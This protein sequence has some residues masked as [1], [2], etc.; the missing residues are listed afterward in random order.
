MNT[1]T[2]WAAPIWRPFAKYR[3]MVRVIAGYALLKRVGRA[4]SVVVSNDPEAPLL[5]ETLRRLRRAGLTAFAAYT[6]RASNLRITLIGSDVKASN[7]CDPRPLWRNLTSA[8]TTYLCAWLSHDHD[9]AASRCLPPN[10][11]NALT[12]RA[13]TTTSLKLPRGC[14]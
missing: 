11:R 13:P 3:R 8:R 5:P 2:T 4:T 7:L 9:S 12:L 14:I 6:P 10:C 1:S